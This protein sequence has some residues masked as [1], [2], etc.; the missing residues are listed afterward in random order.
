VHGVGG[1]NSPKLSEKDKKRYERRIVGKKTSTGLEV[2]KISKHAEQRLA[3]RKL[4]P[5]RIEM[6][7]EQEPVDD[8]KHDNCEIYWHNG[9]AMVLDK[10]SGTVV[11]FM[12]GRKKK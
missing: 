10:H 5:K 11:T 9:S 4:S 3:E 2:K 8:E 1:E 12:W 7:M 6:M